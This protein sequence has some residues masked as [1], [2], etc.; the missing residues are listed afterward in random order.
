[1]LIRR[2][3]PTTLALAVSL[4]APALAQATDPPVFILEGSRLSNLPAGAVMLLAEDIEKMPARNLV[5]VVDS[6]AGITLQRDHGIGDSQHAAN[7]YGAAQPLI[8]LNGRR[9]V[10]MHGAAANLASIPL[11]SVAAI[12]VVPTGGG[13]MYGQGANTG[14]INIVTR[15]AHTGAGGVHLGGG[16][17]NTYEGGL[18]GGTQQGNTQVFG[19]VTG[20]RS[21]GYRDHNKVER[22]AGVF[23]VRQQIDRSVL[24]FT[25]QAGQEELELPG[26][27][28]I[29]AKRKSGT[30]DAKLKQHHYHAMPGIAWHFMQTSVYLEGSFF[31]KNQKDYDLTT[32]QYVNTNIDGYSVSPRLEGHFETGS[33]VHRWD[34]GWDYYL[35]RYDS[36]L[37][38]NPLE[39]ARQQQEGVYG[40]YV[41]D[42]RSWL[43]GHLGARRE[44]VKQSF[45]GSA[46]QPSTDYTLEMYEGGVNVRLAPPLVLSLD[47]ARTAQAP[48]VA[49][50]LQHANALVPQEGKIY[51]ATLAW[52]H[53]H[54]RSSITY[55][56]G[57]FENAVYYDRNSERYANRSDDT[58]RKGFALNSRWQL[59]DHVWL[60]LNA[61]LQ[62]TQYREGAWRNKLV[63]DS[64]RRTGYAQLDWQAAPWLDVGITQHFYSSRFFNGDDANAE[65]RQRGYTWTN[66]SATA[67]VA[68]SRI[69]AGVYN[70]QNRK[71]YDTGYYDAG[72]STLFTYPLP[73]RHFMVDVSFDF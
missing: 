51:S 68:N 65:Q 5:D 71:V 45:F 1:V 3:L 49:A 66:L 63:P 11:Q 2:L 59:D 26:A 24:Y 30:A 40:R 6:V 35:T 61:S 12:E 15:Q 23:D 36:A 44:T 4:T 29:N 8:L 58:R 25:L 9:M 48:N 62:K 57:R 52:H 64:P 10:D 42:Y 69:T 53:D 37:T 55:W 17:Y 70:L 47:A 20:L 31:D 34:A 27:V 50:N 18:W 41:A 39:E 73:E 38:G 19:A 7:A 67:K 56:D 72:S 33:V 14:V 46:T 13:V 28:D 54:Q 22:T 21:D 16:S 32:Q 43:G 60:T